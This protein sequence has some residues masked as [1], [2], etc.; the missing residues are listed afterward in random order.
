MYK[1]YD[2]PGLGKE[3]VSNI[4]TLYMCPKDLQMGRLEYTPH[5]V[6]KAFS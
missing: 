6:R 2:Y 4:W 1:F 3:G 5:S